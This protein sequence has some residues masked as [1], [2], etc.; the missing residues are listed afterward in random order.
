MTAYKSFCL[1]GERLSLPVDGYD[2]DRRKLFDSDGRS[3]ANWGRSVELTLAPTTDPR[4]K[5]Q[6]ILQAESS[7]QSAQAVAI[8]F[9]ADP[10]ILA[11]DYNQIIASVKFGTGG[12]QTELELSVHQG[13]HVV[14]N[15]SFIQVSTRWERQTAGVDGNTKR[16]RAFLAEARGKVSRATRD[17]FTGVVASGNNSALIEV[18]KFTR[19][20]TLHAEEAAA[21][22]TVNNL[23]IQFLVATFVP[24]VA[25]R[26]YSELRNNVNTPLRLDYPMGANAFRVLNN[27]GADRRFIAQ[28]ELDV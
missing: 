28:F 3:Q 5:P 16:V 23:A 15:A 9:E 26:V 6:T 11:F 8:C 13:T 19:A 18:P 7:D 24:P 14:V 17:V 2:G 22:Q 12:T 25:G 10:E 1:P 4:S 20:V 21:Y 27:S